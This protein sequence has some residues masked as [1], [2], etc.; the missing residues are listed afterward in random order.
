MCEARVCVAMWK[1]NST[2]RIPQRKQGS[3][4]VIIILLPG[5]EY[6]SSAC[7]F[8][9]RFT[10]HHPHEWLVSL[11]PDNT[12]SVCYRSSRELLKRSNVQG[13]SS[14]FWAFPKI[15]GYIVV[16]RECIGNSGKEN[17]S[18]YLGFRVSFFG[19]PQSTRALEKPRMSTSDRS[20]K[21]CVRHWHH[22]QDFQSGLAV[23]HQ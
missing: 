14:L 18:Y 17:G 1:E 6:A 19:L 15:R 3:H 16:H 22:G 13:D 12:S 8:Q 21:P 5:K 10:H 23:R 4:A 11:R 2:N 7:S 9:S 20:R